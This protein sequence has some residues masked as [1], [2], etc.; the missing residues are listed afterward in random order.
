MAL[1][2]WRATGENA[3]AVQERIFPPRFLPEEK[4]FDLSFSL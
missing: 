1:K 2:K 3:K 4:T